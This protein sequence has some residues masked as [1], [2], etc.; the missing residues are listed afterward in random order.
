MATTAHRQGAFPISRPYNFFRQPARINRNSER[1]LRPCSSVAAAAPDTVDILRNSEVGAAGPALIPARHANEDYEF[2]RGFR[3]SARGVGLGTGLGIGVAVGVAIAVDAGVAV[4]VAVA[5]GVVGVAVAAAA[6]VGVG[7]LHG[8][9]TI[10]DCGR[11]W[12]LGDESQRRVVALL[13]QTAAS[14]H[15]H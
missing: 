3:T 11:K 2:F 4:A 12:S 14:P 13:N 7:V 6:G 1:A 9:L 5:V 8:L 10:T 15:A